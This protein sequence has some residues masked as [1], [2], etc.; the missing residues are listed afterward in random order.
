[1]EEEESSRPRY[2]E[3]GGS[4]ERIS[5]SLKSI[6]RTLTG[7]QVP[8]STHSPS[9]GQHQEGDRSKEYYPDT[10]EKCPRKDEDRVGRF[11]T[12]PRNILMEIKGN[13]MLSRLRPTATPAKFKNKN[14]Y[15]EYH[16][17][18]GHTT[19]EYRELKRALHEL[20]NQG[21]LNSFLR[22]G[23]GGDHNRCDLEGKKDDDDVNRNRQIIATIIGGIND[24]ELNVIATRVLKP[25]V[26]PIMTFGPEDMHPL[27]TPHNDALVIQLKIVT[28]MARRILVDIG[29]SVDIIT[30]ECLK[31]LQ[32]NEKDLE[33]IETSIV[34]VRG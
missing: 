2:S 20:A 3:A 18:Y 16:E 34:G 15:C 8:R 10:I 5:L 17:N 1:M 23:E 32:Y 27:Q 7:T 31:K 26:G 12:A 6:G 21:Q 24:K 9:N 11:H 33:A 14:N 28:A 25:L 30:L 22:R 19:S 4:E 13:P 29:S